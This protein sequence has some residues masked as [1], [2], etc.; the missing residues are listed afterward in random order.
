MMA[1]SGT[2][3][4][5]ALHRP[6]LPLRL[7]RRPVAG[8]PPLALR[9]AARVAT[10]HDRPHRGPETLRR[11]RLHDHADGSRKPPLPP[12]RHALPVRSPASASPRPSRACRAIVA[13]RLLFP[14]RED[15]SFGRSSSAG[16]RPR[17]CSTGTRTSPPHWSGSP[18]STSPASWVRSTTAGTLAAYEEDRQLTRDGRGLRDRL[19]GQGAPD[20]RPDSLLGALADLPRRAG[21]A[22]RGR[23]LPAAGGIRRAD[24]QPRL[25]ARAPRT[26]RRPPRGA[27]RLP[28]RPRHGGGRGDHGPQQRPRRSAAAERALVE[29]AGYGGGATDGRRRRRPLASSPDRSRSLQG[30]M[31]ITV[32]SPTGSLSSCPTA[33]AVPTPRRRSA[34][35]WRGLRSPSRSAIRRRASGAGARPRPP[36]AR[37]RPRGDRHR[38]HRRAGT[39]PDPPRRGPCAGESVLELYQG[40][41]ISIGPAIEN[42]FYYDFEFPAGVL[43]LGAGLP[44]DRSAHARPREGGRGLRAR[45]S[46]RGEARERFPAEGQD[47][48][49]ELIDDLV[50]AASDPTERPAGDRLALHQRPLHRP[51]PRSPRARAPPPS[52]PS[53]CSP[54][55]APT[56]GG[57]PRGRCSP[58]STGRPSSARTSSPSTSSA[59]SRPARATIASWGGSSASSCSPSSR[60][61]APSGSPRG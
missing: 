39:R 11:Q 49:V 60:P 2:N 29:L 32:P 36:A 30:S 55:P 18:G 6:G 5:Y 56:G 23:G 44:G 53:S 12:L 59:S 4:R 37:R 1:G 42:G 10:R 7:L 40:V 21:A 50:A 47:Y 43:P 58:G 46:A 3:Q 28:R 31:G 45:R 26:R 19:P 9:R 41:K 17:S 24:R 14:G 15:R 33:P 34:R 22:A 8:D 48:K 25:D 13:T 61:G 16:S 35:A 51:L 57:T 52:A 38:A 54:S 27:R 20:G